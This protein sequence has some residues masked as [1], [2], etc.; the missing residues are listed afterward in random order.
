MVEWMISFIGQRRMSGWVHV[1][2]PNATNETTPPLPSIPPFHQR[3]QM[4]CPFTP[5]CREIL[6]FTQGVYI[7]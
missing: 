6:L 4:V 5:L 2:D 1:S 3:R 7:I